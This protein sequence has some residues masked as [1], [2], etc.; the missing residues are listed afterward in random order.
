MWSEQ[1]VVRIVSVRPNAE[2]VVVV[3]YIRPKFENVAMIFAGCIRS[4][5]D[6]NAFVS[7][8]KTTVRGNLA[9]DPAIGHLI[10]EHDWVGPEKRLPLSAQSRQAGEQGADLLRAKHRLASRFVINLPRSID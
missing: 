3:E 9:D 1:I 5:R 4:F 8:D 6:R 10:V 2:L 7:G